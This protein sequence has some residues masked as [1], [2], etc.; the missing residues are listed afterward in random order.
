MH[1][2]HRLREL[3]KAEDDYGFG[4]KS[5]KAATPGEVFALLMREGPPLGVHLVAWCDTLTNLTRAIDRQGLKEFALRVLFQMSPADS[6]QLIDTPMA[7]R[8]GRHR[9]MFIEEGTERPEKFRPYGL[10]EVA[11]L[12]EL[13]ATLASRA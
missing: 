12:R 3:R 13:G 2:L 4:K 1:G 6:S 5:D 7:S 9:A 8:L 11:R 10:P